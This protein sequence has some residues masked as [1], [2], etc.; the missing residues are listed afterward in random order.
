[1][2]SFRR[3]SRRPFRK[4]AYVWDSIFTSR[5]QQSYASDQR[6]IERQPGESIVHAFLRWERFGLDPPL[7][8]FAALRNF[9]DK[10]KEADLLQQLAGPPYTPEI[11]LIDDRCDRTGWRDTLDRHHAARDWNLY[12]RY[13]PSGEC[14]QSSLLTAKGLFQKLA[15]NVRIVNDTR[16]MVF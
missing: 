12:A 16:S 9:L 1:M 11:A 5:Q 13:P 8:N 3:Q 2:E 14:Q 6:R 15:E 7:Y 10:A 4:N